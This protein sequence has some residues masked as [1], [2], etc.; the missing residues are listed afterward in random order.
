M[1]KTIVVKLH[2]LSCHT[3]VIFFYH[4]QNMTVNSFFVSCQ[5]KDRQNIH[6]LGFKVYNLLQSDVLLR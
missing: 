5:F 3:R 2:V 4:K 6:G 1:Q